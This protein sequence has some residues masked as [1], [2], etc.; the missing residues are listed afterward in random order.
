MITNLDVFHKFTSS[1]D[2]TS[3]L[4]PT[5]QWKLRWQ[6]PV[7]IDG[8]EISVAD[9]RVL[10]IDKNLIWARLWN[11]D[12]LVDNSCGELEPLPWN[13]EEVQLTSS[14]LLD[15]LCPLLSWDLWW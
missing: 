12:L 6:W 10:D 2:D 14:G 4:V 1:Y 15:N 3:T 5:D 9:A 13:L 8:M 7:A 11:W